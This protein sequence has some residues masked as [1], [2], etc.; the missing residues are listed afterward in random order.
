MIN[1]KLLNS[2]TGKLILA[3]GTMM[4]IVG[5]VFAYMFIKQN[6]HI[7]L[8]VVLFYGGFFVATISFLLC[9]ILFDIVTK[10]L[11]FFV[12]GM[13]KLLKGVFGCRIGIHLKDE[14]CCFANF[15]YFMAGVLK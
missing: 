14:L 2:L 10:P 7:K 12:D 13:N 9:L 8:E 11:L 6:P 15:F 3:I 5:L 1:K 4:L